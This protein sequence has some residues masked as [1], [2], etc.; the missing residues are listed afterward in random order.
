MSIEPDDTMFVA[1]HGE[2]VPH[3]WRDPLVASSDAY[4]LF[5]SRSSAMGWLTEATSDASGGLW[6]MNDAGQGP[7]VGSEPSH[8]AWFQVSLTA[9]VPGD[10]PLPVQAFLSCAGDVTTRLGTLSLRAVQVLLPVRGPDPSAETP[11]GTSS[12]LGG[13][14][15]LLQDAGWFADGDPRRRTAVRMTLD[16]GRDPSVRSAAPG[17]LGWM[18][19]FEQDVLR[20]D[21]FSLTD[22]HPV[23]ASPVIDELWHGPARHRATFHGDLAEWSTDALGW[24]AAFLAEAASLHG[25]ATPLM[26]TIDRPEEG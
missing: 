22:D 10:R 8:I 4:S 13:V 14:I 20:C 9:P 21:S 5:L 15:P 6:G 17:M 3:P 12:R 24:L 7:G 2:L 11:P 26:L 25:V 16:G 1:L 18:R 19:G 23:P